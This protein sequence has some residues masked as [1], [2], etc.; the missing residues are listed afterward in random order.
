[1]DNEKSLYNND[2]LGN[3]FEIPKE[4]LRK[5]VMKKVK[6]K[7]QKINLFRSLKYD[8]QEEGYILSKKLA[9]DILSKESKSTKSKER[10]TTE[11]LTNIQMNRISCLETIQF[12]FVKKMNL[13]VYGNHEGLLIISKIE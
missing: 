11:Y 2:F 12:C 9:E 6:A 7:G 4:F 1:M 13:L 10:N 5:N 8:P 3:I